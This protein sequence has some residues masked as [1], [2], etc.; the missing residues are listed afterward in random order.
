M[1]ISTGVS[2]VSFRVDHTQLSTRRLLTPLTDQTPS[3]P[4]LSALIAP[5]DLSPSAPDLNA[6]PAVTPTSVFEPDARL[7]IMIAMVEYLSGKS[8]SGYRQTFSA[9][10]EQTSYLPQ[11][12][13]VSLDVSAA[14]PAPTNPEALGTRH[15]VEIHNA[16]R[17]AFSL[18][19]EVTTS[20]G[21][22]HSVQLMETHERQHRQT[23]SVSASEAA[24]FIDPLVLNLE[25]SLQFSHRT[26]AFD[27]D[28]DGHNEEFRQLGQGSFFLALD[29]NNDGKINNG[30]ELFGTQSGNGFA[31]LRL[32]DE[33]GNGLIDKGDSIFYA[34]KLFRTDTQELTSLSEKQI[35]AIGLNSADTPFT[36]TDSDGQPLA[37]LRQSS[38]YLRE[39]GQHG[40]VQHIDLAV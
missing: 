21:K 15:Q 36:F 23:L 30:H 32:Y 24:K 19:S 5:R 38:F 34:L 28:S 37:Q 26:T 27:L 35:I 16:E 33:D 8:L 4:K 14:E 18:V 20:D 11:T 6:T 13:E 17:L 31:D 2:Q 7:R 9:T 1:D 22:S 25:G 39:N 12:I 10:A 29:L 40:T 3:R